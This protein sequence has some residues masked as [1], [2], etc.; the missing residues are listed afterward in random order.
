M[1]VASAECIS[2]DCSNGFGTYIYDSGSKY[3]GESKNNQAHGQGTFIYA[4]GDEYVGGWKD[5]EMHGQGIFT[6]QDGRKEEGI[7]FENSFIQSNS[8][9]TASENCSSDAYK[10]AEFWE[11][12]DPQEAYDFGEKIKLL[13]K[14]KNLGGIYELT[15]TELTSGPRKKFAL[16][17]NF[18]EVIPE[19]LA[20]ILLE[21]TSPCTPIGWRG[22][23]LGNGI[24][25]YNKT[26]DGWR[27]FSIQSPLAEELSAQI[28]WNINGDIL[29]PQCFSR[30]WMSSDNYEEFAKEYNITDL[31][32]FKA[33]PG[34]YFGRE[35]RDYT[36]LNTP[37]WSAIDYI[38]LTN[39]VENCTPKNFEYKIESI[40]DIYVHTQIDE[41]SFVDEYYNIIKKVDVDKCSMLA[42]NINAKCLE[43][44]FLG[45]GDFSGGS[46]GFD[47]S[48]GIYGLFDIQ[49]HGLTI[50]PLVLFESMNEGLNY[51]D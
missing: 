49:N 14:Q 45:T 10:T 43:S 34:E 30:P 38:T 23:T 42:P 44:Y 28:G 46:M 6:Y 17:Q 24:I 5:D 39:E 15:G 22:F 8:S 37:D 3:I 35:I 16:T 41:L 51:L 21:D 29:H 48:Y 31:N 32:N 19:S 18:D 33:Y 2:G 11:Y 12:Y 20:L 13:L 47:S 40:N 25:W 36:P 7:F 26:D 1:S 4:N 50:V 9:Y 27:I